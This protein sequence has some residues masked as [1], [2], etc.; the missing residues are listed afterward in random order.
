MWGPPPP[1]LRLDFF[2]RLRDNS[3]ITWWNFIRLGG[4]VKYDVAINWLDFEWD[5]IAG[6][7]GG[8]GVPSPLPP[9]PL[10]P[11]PVR[12]FFHLRDN[13]KALFNNV[14]SLKKILNA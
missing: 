7:G 4:K 12:F 6:G 5:C 13:L 14:A 10:P 1:P 8:G 9:S 11:T 3:S 2:F